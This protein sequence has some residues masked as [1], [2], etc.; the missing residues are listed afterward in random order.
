[1]LRKFFWGAV[2]L[3]LAMYASWMVATGVKFVFKA[4]AAKDWPTTMGVVISS[5]AVKDCS[6]SYSSK[7]IYQYKVGAASY[8]SDQL[9]FGIAGC[10]SKSE[11]QAETNEYPVNLPVTVHFNPEAPSEATI[12]VGQVSNVTWWLII[13]MPFVIIMFVW[14][15]WGFLRGAWIAFSQGQ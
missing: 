7:V 10:G 3:S 9:I 5:E 13:T 4:H 1:M 2:L 11:A 14:I 15:S 12:L 6:K 8:E